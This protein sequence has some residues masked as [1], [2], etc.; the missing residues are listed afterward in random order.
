[1]GT[2]A[3]AD[4]ITR[5]VEELGDHRR[6]RDAQRELVGAGAIDALLACLR[7]DD[8]SVVRS[9]VEALGELKATEAIEP[10]LAMLQQG[11]MS[12]DVCS[13]LTNIT[14]Q[15]LG[16]DTRRWREWLAEPAAVELLASGHEKLI[17]RAEKSLG[18]EAKGS[19][20]VF[21]FRLDLVVSKGRISIV[22]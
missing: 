13:A 15:H 10:L 14:G 5:W 19:G 3:S 17:R 4:Q 21:R 2:T 7:R 9:A 11:T 1:M 8:R 22:A 12:V 6:R 16:I 20:D 18:I